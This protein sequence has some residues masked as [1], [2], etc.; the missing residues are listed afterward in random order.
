M[1]CP[2]I[3]FSCRPAARDCTDPLLSVGQPIMP[4]KAQVA[5]ERRPRDGV[6]SRALGSLGHTWENGPT[7]AKCRR[8]NPC[9]QHLGLSC[10]ELL[11][12]VGLD[13]LEP[14]A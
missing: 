7:P 4:T 1:V 12:I 5:E 8:T 11:T 13:R 3:G 2:E 6:A 10:T 14:G 9:F